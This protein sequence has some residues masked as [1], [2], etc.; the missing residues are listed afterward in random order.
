MNWLFLAMVLCSPVILAPEVKNQLVIWN[1]GQGQF[2]TYVIG[3]SCLHFD[4]GGERMDAPSVRRHCGTKSN[5]AFFSHWDWDHIN[6]FGLARRLLPN[7]CVSLAP[8]GKTDSPVK[9]KMFEH[10]AI[11]SEKFALVRELE[12]AKRK[13]I[14]SNQMSRVL[15]IDGWILIPGDSTSAEERYWADKVPSSVRLLMLGHHGSRTSTS[16]KLMS[17]LRRLQVAVATAR[18]KRY[19]HPHREVVYRVRKNKTPVL[20]TEDW[21]NLHFELR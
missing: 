17:R 12:F 6:F 19:G 11:C 5:A 14:K 16:K 10:A 3:D 15:V 4:M 13:G 8:G 2:A 7:L 9:L 20:K 21:G 18:T 1:V